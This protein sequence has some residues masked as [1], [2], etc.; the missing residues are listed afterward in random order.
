[1]HWHSWPRDLLKYAFPPVSL[2]AQTLSK[3]REDRVQI[4]LVAP[5]WPNRTW[6]SDLVLLASAPPWRIP[7][8]KGL[9]SRWKGTI[10]HPHPDLW[11]LWSLDMTRRTSET[12]HP[13]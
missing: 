7:L 1:M 6:F 12:F 13:Q 5:F 10:W 8:R 4:L 11:D 2:I 9:I 3:V